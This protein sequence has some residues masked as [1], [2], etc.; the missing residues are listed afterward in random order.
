MTRTTPGA[1]KWENLD[2]YLDEDDFGV[3]VELT[4][5]VTFIG[6][7]QAT[8]ATG[9]DLGGPAL[10][11]KQVDVDDN[12]VTH[13]TSITVDGETRLV[14]GLRFDGYGMVEL[15]LDADD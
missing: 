15:V 11:V 14:A 3:D 12:S 7:Y 8:S 13:G 9:G 1:V 2:E 6:M 5:G 10:L 4:T